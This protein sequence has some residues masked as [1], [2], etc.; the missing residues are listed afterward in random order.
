MKLSMLL[1]LASVLPQPLADQTCLA[2]TVYLEARSES[3][4]GQYAVAEV[5]MRRRD[6]GTWGDSVCEVVTSP[7]Q[8]ALTTTASNFEVTDL[9]SWTKAWKI[10]GDSISNWS[11]PQGERTVYVPRADAFAT[12]AVTPQWS[13]KRVKTIGEHAFYAVNN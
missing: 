4:I 7:R 6:R 5:A 9:N 12:L 1:W 3:T 2:T 10:A 11:L 8:F 13:N